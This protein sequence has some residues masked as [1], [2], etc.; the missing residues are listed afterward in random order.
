MPGS[1]RQYLA[2]VIVGTAAGLG[3]FALLVVTRLLQPAS[4]FV[5]RGLVPRPLGWLTRWARSRTF[6][7]WSP[8][9]A[10]SAMLVSHLAGPLGVRLRRLGVSPAGSPVQADVVVVGTGATVLKSSVE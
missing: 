2:L 8:D 7:F 10:I 6:R 9:P 1:I 5:R 4:T 3:T